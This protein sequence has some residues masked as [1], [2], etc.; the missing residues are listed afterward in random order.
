MFTLRKAADRGHA[1]FGWL[2]SRH[3]F[4]FGDYYDPEF[5]GFHTLRVINEDH[6]APGGGFP[7]HPHR[8]MEIFSYVVSGALEHRDSM[9]N[10]KRLGPGEIQI[11][12]AGSGVTHSEFNP[13]QT[14]AAHFLQIWIQPSQKGLAPRYSEWKPAPGSE[15]QAKVLLISPDGHE[16]SATITQNAFVYRIRLGAGERIGHAIAED[17]YVWIQLISGS[18]VSGNG[19]KV[20]AGDGLAVEGESEILLECIEPM[21][22]LLFE[23]R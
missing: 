17:C 12:S 18:Y 23:L 5:L 11:M 16:N 21:E 1:N 22:A 9:G 2:D 13:S 3:S 4:S 6:V 8:D 7:T 19:A 20:N 10:Q 15:T 14:E